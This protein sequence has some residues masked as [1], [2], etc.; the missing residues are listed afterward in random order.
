MYR[1]P[2]FCLYLTFQELAGDF[3][4]VFEAM[5]SVS[6]MAPELLH[7]DKSGVPTARPN[8][9]HHNADQQAADIWSAACTAFLI[10]SGRPLFSVDYQMSFDDQKASVRQ[11]QQ[12]LVSQMQCGCRDLIWHQH[13][14]V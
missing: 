4:D 11:Q 5:G 10:I 2:L 6:N 12:E 8:P 7:V 14:L 3:I 13:R 9:T 1:T